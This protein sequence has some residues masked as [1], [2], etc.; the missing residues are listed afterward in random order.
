MKK[1][2]LYYIL[3]LAP[4]L[5]L[6]IYKENIKLFTIGLLGYALIYRPVI[7][8][9]RLISKGIIKPNRWWILYNPF[10]RPK[11]FKELYFP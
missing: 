10:L 8:G 7:D 3:I 11:Y 5:S 2:I 4:L 9:H 6:L 1:L